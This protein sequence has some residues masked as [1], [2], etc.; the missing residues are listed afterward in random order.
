MSITK[1][2]EVLFAEVDATAMVRLEVECSICGDTHTSDGNFVV[3]HVDA[4]L[5]EFKHT[6]HEAGWRL[7]KS[8]KYGQLGLTCGN[9]ISEESN[10]EP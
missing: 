8:E 7:Y 1:E 2:Q 4:E 3:S 10:V 5:D 6:L 9:C